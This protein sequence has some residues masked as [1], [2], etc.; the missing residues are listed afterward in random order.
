MSYF[1]RKRLG[2]RE[3]FKKFRK[4]YFLR[5]S[6][7]LRKLSSEKTE[8]FWFGVSNFQ[9]E[10]TKRNCWFRCDNIAFASKKKLNKSLFL[11]LGFR[12]EN[13]ILKRRNFM[14]E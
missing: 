14:F 1:G 13:P 10:N 9:N 12:C 4:N 11:D 7:S 8:R 5:T 2:F 3:N 6:Y